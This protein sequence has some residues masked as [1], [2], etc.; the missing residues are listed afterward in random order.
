MIEK[1]QAK[2]LIKAGEG[3]NG[4]NAAGLEEVGADILVTGNHVFSSNDYEDA[5]ESLKL[6]F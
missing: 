2:V 3:A 1:K 6:E 5:I 4:L